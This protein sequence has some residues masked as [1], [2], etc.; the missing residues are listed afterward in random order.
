MLIVF[1]L[2]F[3]VIL[4]LIDWLFLSFSDFVVFIENWFSS[5]E[6]FYSHASLNDT[7]WFIEMVL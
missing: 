4:E 7:F 1:S 6:L 3:G 2:F 5:N